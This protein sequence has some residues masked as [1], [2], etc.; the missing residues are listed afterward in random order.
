MDAEFSLPRVGLIGPGIDRGSNIHRSDSMSLRDAERAGEFPE[1]PGPV[2]HEAVGCPKNMESFFVDLATHS[3]D[4]QIDGRITPAGS[5]IYNTSF[6]RF[7]VAADTLLQRA[8]FP[9]RIYCRWLYDTEDTTPSSAEAMLRS[10]PEFGSL[11]AVGDCGLGLPKTL[12]DLMKM[13][14][15]PRTNVQILIRSTAVSFSK[16]E[17]SSSMSFL[18]TH[19]SPLTL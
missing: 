9:E 11:A 10:L 18:M 3:K 15:S 6:N 8:I 16:G 14:R 1:S 5:I 12:V 19:V 17:S 2:E 7:G 13:N 4:V